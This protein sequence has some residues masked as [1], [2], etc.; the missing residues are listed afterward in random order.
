MTDCCAAFRKNEQSLRV[1]RLQLDSGQRLI[2]VRYPMSLLYE[3][4]LLMKELSA[5]VRKL[6]L[7]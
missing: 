2:G 1:I 4:S 3:V 6:S 7:L 5:Q